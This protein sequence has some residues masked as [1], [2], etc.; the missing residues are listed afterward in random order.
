MAIELGF[1]GYREC[2]AKTREG[3]DDVFNTCVE[4]VFN[5][6]VKDKKEQEENARL[7]KQNSKCQI[8]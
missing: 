5:R 8:M 3:L 2:S 1:Q 4:A 6:D 7:M